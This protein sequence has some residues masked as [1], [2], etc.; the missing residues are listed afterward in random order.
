MISFFKKLK[1]DSKVKKSI[2]RTFMLAAVLPIVVICTISLYILRSQLLTRYKEQSVSEAQRVSSILLDTTTAVYQ[3]AETLINNSNCKK[4]FGTEGMTEDMTA[5]YNAITSSLAVYKGNTASISSIRIYTD[6]PNIPSTD[7][8]IGGTDFSEVN[9]QL[10]TDDTIWDSWSTMTTTDLWS[11]DNYE[12]SLVRR[13]G[14]VSQKYR[15]YLVVTLDNNNLKNRIDQNT[16]RVLCDVDHT[17]SFYTNDRTLK[18]SLMV[19]PDNEGGLTSFTGTL[20]YDGEKQLT[21]IRSF[22]PYN[23]ANIIYIS[24]TDPDALSTITGLSR[25]LI[26]LMLID[27]FVPFLLILFYADFFS[28]RVN[29]LKNAMHKASTGNYDIIEQVQ[30]DDEFTDTFLDLKKT[31]EMIHERESAFYEAKIKEQK[32]INQQQQMEYSVLANQINPHFL[33]NTLET[34]RMLSLSH[35]DREAANAIKLLGKSMRYV[36]DNNG[37]S[38]VALSAELGYIKTYLSIQELRFGERVHD[39]IIIE[40]GLNPS[41]VRILPLLLQPIVENAITHGLEGMETGGLVTI[42]AG[43]HNEML[44]LEVKDNGCGMNEDALASLLYKIQNRNPDEGRHVG[45]YNIHRRLKLLYGDQAE[46][47]VESAP[48][49]GTC[50]TIQMPAEN[51]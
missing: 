18:Q 34:I 4:L 48:Q 27:A 31:V 44:I 8:I 35:G 49:K 37:T 42:T 23:T 32:L 47:R 46:F 10:P 29:T 28:G 12:L 1:P 2:I 15:A 24:V 16:Y 6:N 50:I 41:E 13:V 3:S 30:G 39:S 21:T 22:R 25:I 33:Y 9:W 11:N 14:I 40:D 38:F 45:L 17:E 36:L 20:E 43:L 5:M 19:L 7:Y 26:I 51:I